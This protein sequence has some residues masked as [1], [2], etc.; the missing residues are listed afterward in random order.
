MEFLRRTLGFLSTHRSAQRYTVHD[1]VGGIPLQR[2]R[3]FPAIRS[4]LERIAFAKE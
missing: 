4:W 3:S 1:L 2:M